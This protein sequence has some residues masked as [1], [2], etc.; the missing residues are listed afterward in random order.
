MIFD[1][2]LVL[3]YAYTPSNLSRAAAATF[4]QRKGRQVVSMASLWEVAIKSSLRR[5][6]FNIDVEELAA[7]LGAEGFELLPVQL[8][9]LILLQQLPLIHRDPFDRLLVAQAQTEH[10][11]LF[12][13][14]RTLAGYG[15]WVKVV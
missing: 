8:P 7:T 9:H 15:H 13:A 1:T 6:D 12:T 2:Q 5:P 3:W 10:L 11:P 4:S 14:D